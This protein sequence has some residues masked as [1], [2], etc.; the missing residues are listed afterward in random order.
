[1]EKDNVDDRIQPR[2]EP[3]G[4]RR[5]EA[6]QRRHGQ[7]PEIDVPECISI[8]DAGGNLLAFARMDGAFV[9]SIEFPGEGADRRLLRR[10]DREFPAGMDLKLAIATQG[11]RVNLPAGCRSSSTAM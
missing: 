5:H 6:S 10:A 11:K 4:R 1:M 7:G 3:H 8:V 2:R 9:L